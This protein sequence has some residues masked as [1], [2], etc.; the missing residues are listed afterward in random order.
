MS[1]AEQASDNI[2][3]LNTRFGV[4]EIDRSNAIKMP[5]GMVGFSEHKEFALTVPAHPALE[6]YMLLQC[7]TEETLTFILKPYLYET[8]VLRPEDLAQVIQKHE[9]KPE[10]L[11]VMLVTTIRQTP[12]GPRK[13]VNMR[14]PVFIDT[15]R[16]IAWQNIF[17][18]DDYNVRHPVH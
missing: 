2:I 16:Q 9:I 8:E 6:G 4:M 11:A 10:N 7:I 14:A 12:A 17:N 1:T 5:M 18:S 13:S 15:E 3:T